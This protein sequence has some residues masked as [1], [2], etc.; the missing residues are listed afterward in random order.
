MAK[1]NDIVL[2]AGKGRDDYMAIKD[3]YIKYSDYET[4][5]EHFK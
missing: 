3:K 5:K 4:I 1:E 2:I